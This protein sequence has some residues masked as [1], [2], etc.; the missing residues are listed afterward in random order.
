MVD[1][2]CGLLL[3]RAVGTHPILLCV[4]LLLLLSVILLLLLLLFF[5]A[6]LRL[7]LLLLCCCALSCFLGCC[8]PRKRASCVKC[9]RLGSLEA[10]TRRVCDSYRDRHRSPRL[11]L[12][13][14]LVC[15]GLLL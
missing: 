4:C 6:L 12:L 10:C 14:L 3:L 15:G 7:L 2:N 1:H 5:A 9:C 8:Q 11:G 13:W